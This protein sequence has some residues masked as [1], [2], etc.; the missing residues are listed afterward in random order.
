MPHIPYYYRV[1]LQDKMAP[2]KVNLSFPNG[3]KK[4][5]QILVF[6]STEHKEPGKSPSD[7]P[8]M[9]KTLITLNGV[10]NPK[11]QKLVFDKPFLYV[12]VIAQQDDPAAI[13]IMARFR[14]DNPTRVKQSNTE[15]KDGT[16]AP[17]DR[18]GNEEQD[19]KQ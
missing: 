15:K 9:N 2:L 19:N 1:R 5:N 3:S 7:H 6:Y 18:N 11:T 8:E 16:P 4:S 13:K 14:E 17:T 12:C 10:V